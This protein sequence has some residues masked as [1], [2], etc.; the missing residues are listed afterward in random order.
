MEDGAGFEATR[1][2]LPSTPPVNLWMLSDKTKQKIRRHTFRAH[3][4][5]ISWVD[6]AS[7]MV[8]HP[9]VYPVTHLPRFLLVDG[10]GGDGGG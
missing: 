7:L 5:R 9:A 6:S 1:K 10:G 4:P 8:A 3:A 2:L